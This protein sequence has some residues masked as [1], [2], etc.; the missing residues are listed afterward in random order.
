MNFIGSTGRRTLFEVVPVQGIGIRRYSAFT[1]EDEYL[2]APGSQLKV[3]EIKADPSG[4]YTI[5]LEELAGGR[6]VS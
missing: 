3:A 5:R 1:G 2:L 4:L 6:L